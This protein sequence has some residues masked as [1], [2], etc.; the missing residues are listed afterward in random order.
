MAAGRDDVVVDA[1]DVLK[2]DHRLVE[3]LFTSFNQAVPQQ[4]DPLARR[5]CKMLRI[6]TQVEEELFYPYV[7]RAL[8][9]ESVI[10][11][12]EHEHA[13]AK[14]AIVRVESMTSNDS[15]FKA[16][17]AE[18][19]RL[20]AHHVEEEENVMFARLREARV[21]LRALGLTLSE[22]R[23]TLM[24]VLGLHGDDEE[25]ALNQREIQQAIIRA[26]QQSV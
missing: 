12:A 8:N 21:D 1:I 24:D 6:H 10:E 26:R 13:E 4:L 7:R 23:D 20:V 19:N 18:L 17:V 2:R 22:R 9:D 15:D 16:A 5:V 14:Q 3:E 25:G 11:H